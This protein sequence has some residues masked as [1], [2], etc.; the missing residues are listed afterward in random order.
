MVTNNSLEEI[1]ALLRASRSVAILS[2]YN[3]DVDAYGS[4]CGLALTLRG[5]GL[6]VTCVNE[7]GIIP[8]YSFLPGVSEVERTLPSA[9]PDLVIVCDCGD[10]KRVG[11]TLVGQ[12][13][14]A[15]KLLNIDHHA[16]NELFGTHN[17]VHPEASSTSEL[18]LHIIDA[19]GVSCTPEVATCLYAGIVGDTGSFR[20][21]SVRASTF[22]VARRLVEAGA[23]PSGIA[24]AM[25]SRTSLAAVRLQAEALAGLT[26]HF[27]GRFAEVIVPH[28]QYLK[29]GASAEDVDALAERARDIEGVQVSAL[30]RSDDG[31]LW[32]VSLRSRSPETDVSEVARHFGGGGHR[33]AAAFRFR[34][35]LDELRPALLTQIER[36]LQSSRT[37][38]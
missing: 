27:D 13:E 12:V 36:L 8:R 23:S 35:S 11:E 9:T 1:A 17:Y 19:L 14:A 25:F 15:A 21:S 2:H 34:R 3:P 31:V 16:S 4:S 22:E 30:I 5:L 28:E 26:T 10:I 7:S 29:H 38:G 20:Y 37:T 24:D 18:I 32:R 6:T 33:A